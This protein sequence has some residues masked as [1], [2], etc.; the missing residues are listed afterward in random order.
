MAVSPSKKTPA[1]SSGFNPVP[2]CV[3][4]GYKP[5]HFD[6]IL[7]T[8]PNVGFLEAHPENYMV[9][10]GPALRQLEAMG[11]VYPLSLHAVGLS[12]G[13]SG[14]V[15]ADHLDRLHRLV[16]RF[17]PALISDHLSWCRDGEVY[18][19]DL[20]PMPY[21]EE[22]LT[23]V[24]DNVSHVQDVLGRP[25]LIENPSTYLKP[26]HADMDEA[27]FLNALCRRSGCGILFDVNNL[28]VSAA[29]V[30]LDVESYLAAMSK[31]VVGEIHLAGH[32]TETGVEGTVLI[33]DHGST[34]AD[35]VWDLFS[36]AAEHLGPIP[37]LIEWDTDVPPLEILVGEAEKATNLIKKS[38]KSES[39]DHAA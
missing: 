34:V 17:Q 23:V 7:N 29:N 15:D 31:D 27:E 12:L 28:Y 18:L 3:G 19:P 11:E 6:G 5:V 35:P 13:T 16:D 25:L 24:S 1:L 21:T 32:K 38:L 10:G 14:P 36:R 30:G 22:A 37:T 33:D 20:L 26:K 39:N 8:L 4:I 2:P 9:A